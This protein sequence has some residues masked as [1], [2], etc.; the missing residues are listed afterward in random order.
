MIHADPFIIN[1]R[2]G[3]IITI[4]ALGDIHHLLKESDEDRFKS[5]LKTRQTEQTFF[6]DMGDSLD[7][8]GPT[9]KYF[10]INRV[11]PRLLVSTDKNKRLCEAIKPLLNAEI[12][13]LQDIYNKYTNPNE[14]I[15][16]I[17][18]NH[19]LFMLS[20]GLDFVQQIC[21]QLKHRYLGYQAYVPLNIRTKGSEIPL[22]IFATHGFGG[23]GARWEGAALNA[24]IQHSSRYEGWDVAIYG[25]R[26]DKWIK[27]LSRI[28]PSIN[29]RTGERW[30]K[31]DEKLICQSGTYLRT[32]SHSVWPSYSE[33]KGMHPRPIGCVSIQ[34]KVSRLTENG[35][36]HFKIQ[37]LNV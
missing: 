18:G 3:E 9:H 25:H 5:D 35:S 24:Y 19:P 26:H 7:C 33:A 37:F 10:Q 23:A 12:D 22:M 2:E 20:N 36:R 32:L 11:K 13:D 16:H 21:F 31:E 4:K 34:F 6:I 30:I 1:A 15:G 8:I 27:A 17:S 29:M 14:W 28:R